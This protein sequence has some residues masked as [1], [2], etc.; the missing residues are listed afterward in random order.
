M[1]AA[2]V[3]RVNPSRIA[4]M[5]ASFTCTGVSKSGSPR[6]KSTTSIPS[7][8]IRLAI[9]A[10]ASV[11]EGL[12]FFARRDRFTIIV[13][14]SALLWFRL[15]SL[16]LVG[17][18]LQH[19]PDHWRH[20]LGNVAAEQRNFFDQ[21]RAEIRILLVG[22]QKYCFDLI[23]QLSIHQRHLKLVF[24][25]GK[26]AQTANDHTRT[27]STHIIHQQT[28]KGIDGDASHASNGVLNDPLSLRKGEQ[29]G[30]FRV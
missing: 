5:A 27:P 6:P 1:P 25:V 11:A 21:S 29:R 20:E 3:Y 23:V 4:V 12:V 28:V 10:I 7:A 13:L 22:H 16:T 9:A 14:V 24:E 8:F 26:R 2:A 17:S 15:C 18:F 19:L 30:L